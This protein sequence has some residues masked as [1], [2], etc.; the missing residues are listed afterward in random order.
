MKTFKKIAAQGEITIIRISRVKKDGVHAGVPLQAENGRFVIGHS[1]TGHHHV[2]DA[3][4]FLRIR[5]VIDD[6]SRVLLPTQLVVKE[7]L[8]YAN[9]LRDLRLRVQEAAHRLHE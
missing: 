2:I 1:E 9:P 8:R 6:L 5:K 3:L 4:R 7:E